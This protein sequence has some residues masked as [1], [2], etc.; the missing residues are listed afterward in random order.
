MKSRAK[1]TRVLLCALLLLSSPLVLSLEEISAKIGDHDPRTTTTVST[2][3]VP[4]AL[5][6]TVPTATNQTV[7][8][9]TVTNST[10][11]TVTVT[12]STRIIVWSTETSSLTLTDV[13]LIPG[14]VSIPSEMIP[15]MII[16]LVMVVLTLLVCA[17]ILRSRSSRALDELDG[18]RRLVHELRTQSSVTVPA[19][20]LTASSALKR[21]LELGVLQPK[22]Y[23]EKKML[24]ERLEKKMSAKQLLDEG[25]ISEEQYDALTRKQD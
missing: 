7:L 23:M 6:T 2:T 22:E 24:A 21:L 3:S 15:A 17:L 16:G 9:T 5:T 19:T 20:G 12:N 8:T 1:Y 25:L 14:L 13:S 4:R 10:S 11:I 18:Q